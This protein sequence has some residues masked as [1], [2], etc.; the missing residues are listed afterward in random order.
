MAHGIDVTHAAAAARRE[1]LLELVRQGFGIEEGLTDPRI[2]ISYSAYRKARE[3]WKTWAAE[4]DVARATMYLHGRKL[5]PDELDSGQFAFRYFKR[6]RTWFQ[7]RWVDEVRTMH[8]GDILLTLWPPEYG[9]TSTF[10]DMATETICRDNEWRSTV[11]SENDTI[12]KKIIGVVRRRLESNGPTPGLVKDWGPFR[13]HSGDQQRAGQ[14]WNAE[15]FTIRQ[16]QAVDQRDFTMMA[17][18][19]KSSSVSIR[20]DHL[21]IDDI[22]S[23]K[24]LAQTPTMLQTFR[25][26]LL[27]RPGEDGIT[28]I[29]GTIV[30]D[31]D[32]YHGLLDDD[33][34]VDSGILHVLRFPAIQFDEKGNPSALWPQKHTLE[35]LERIRV[36]IKDFTFDRTYMMEP[37]RS[38]TKTTFSEE[39]WARAKNPNLRLNQRL[40]WDPS[41]SKPTAVVALDPGMDPGVCCLQGW[42]MQPEKMAMRYFAESDKFLSN[43]EIVAQVAGSFRFLAQDYRITHLIVE[44]KNFQRGLARDERLIALC[45]SYNCEIVEHLTGINKYDADIGI[46]S[47]AGDWK[48]GSIELPYDDADE[49]TMEEI[50]EFWRQLKKWRPLAKGNL[51]RQDRVVTMWFAWIWWINNRHR[52]SVVAAPIRRQGLPYRAT[53]MQPTGSRY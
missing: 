22:T 29:S 16:M 42:E 51:L 46:R 7:Q 23:K 5:K 31:G 40:A 3:R 34:L 6:S 32:F 19:W 8:R 30:D 15:A 10:E 39:G 53:R 33:E 45:R 38:K 11:V 36:K 21:H 28:T 9:K 17:I 20:T 4:I 18:G 43:E 1:L 2:N 49:A 12:S 52:L 27:S 26:D 48:A 24:T 35:Q 14:P 47:M 13:G 37:G 25:Q 50:N 41:T 44:A